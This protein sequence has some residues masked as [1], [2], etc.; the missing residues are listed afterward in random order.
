MENFRTQESD[1]EYGSGFFLGRVYKSHG[2]GSGLSCEAGSGFGQHLTGSDTLE[3]K[4]L[5]IVAYLN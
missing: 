5:E 4:F 1:P 2:S 3:A